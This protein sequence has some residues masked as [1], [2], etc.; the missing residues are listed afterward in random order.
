MC[1]S[2]ERSLHR[3]SALRTLVSGAMLTWL[4]TCSA[5]AD[6]SPE[7]PG[8]PD[9]EIPATR[10]DESTTRT[11]AATAQDPVTGLRAPE[12][13]EPVVP[14]Y[15]AG[16]TSA[17]HV[18]LELTI[19]ASGTVISAE[20][21]SSGGAAFDRAALDAAARLR[22]TPAQRDGSAIEA[23]IP[24]AFD[25]ETVPP[26]AAQAPTSD[27]ST[28]T[29]LAPAQPALGT[30][31]HEGDVLGT[32]ELEVRGAPPL[33]ETTRHTIDTQE[34]RTIAG[35][36]G[37]VLRSVE[38]MP[39]VA[40]AAYG[41]GLLIV[42][43]S[44]PEDSQVFVDGTAIPY[45][46]HV[47]DSSSVIPG[48]MLDRLDFYPG[49]F[50]PE[51]GRGMGGVIDVGLRSPR[52]DQLHGLA[53]LDVI[54][55]RLLLETPLGQHT[56]LML[57]VR[58]SWV[59]AWIGSVLDGLDAALTT[60]PVYYDAQATLEHDLSDKTR[61]RVSLFGA[62]DRLKVVVKSPDP[63]DPALSGAFGGYARFVRAQL[64]LDSELGSGTRWVNTASWGITD[65]KQIFGSN[66][67]ASTAH[68]FTLRSELRAA[69]TRAVTLETGIDAVAL[70]DDIHATFRPYPPS[71]ALDSPYF[72]R[73]A[74]SAAALANLVRPALYAGFELRPFE[75]LKLLP[76][77]RADY[78]HDLKRVTVDPRLGVRWDVVHAPARGVRTTLKAGAGMYHQP[79]AIEQ[80]NRLVGTPGLE[81][82]RALQ[83][84]LGVEQTLSGG[85]EVSLE[86]FFKRLDRLV[87]ARA[88]ESRLIGA[89]F[90]NT[91][92]G[93][94][95]GAEAL[96]K[97]K[98]ER[99]V[100]SGWIAYT[101]SRSERRDA[102]GATLHTFA[103]D[104][105]HILSAVG[106]L[107]LG[108][109][110]LL[111]ARFRYITGA[112]FT[113]YLGGIVDLD[114]GAY[115]PLASA[116]PYSARIAA[117]HQLDLRIEKAW[118]FEAFRLTAYLE[119][120]NA[121]NHHNPEGVVYS[122]DFSERGTASG[123]PILP[124][125][126]VRGEL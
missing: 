78:T 11:D 115:A 43:G 40:R 85:L 45:A 114:A 92:S 68:S 73:P 56:G 25:F 29:A 36:N 70:I 49:N 33:R 44:A 22:F 10:A 51:F 117:F 34:V 6:E 32:L 57:G 63:H 15:P 8:A 77:V 99:G 86:G 2:N 64:R 37:D 13:V 54:D 47:G 95:Y 67:F 123:I 82:N 100:L 1:D 17:A 35:T 83:L 72:A 61:L 96:V 41:Q 118:V 103:Y 26:S 39:G 109:G 24:F 112:P 76:S 105:T 31:E 101:L 90:E 9:A 46:Y 53:Q 23:R 113:P 69:L 91:G 65:S 74:R 12:L 42:R 93:R 62:D 58:R 27:A 80:S 30:S 21:A 38:T 106:N 116:R 79:P 19:D 98:P 28:T 126:G 122:Y 102:P 111:G 108:A 52:R 3:A 81:S 124:V 18:A 48:D 7:T 89:R 14:A 121:Y 119:L 20:V 4:V 107:E 97:Y 60:A 50:G 94:A 84:S 104:Q 75:S 110:W 55:G 87:V 125:L 120:R 66:G 5:H 71:D 59:D 88:D 16:E